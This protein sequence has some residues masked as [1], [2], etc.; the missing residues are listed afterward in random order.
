MHTITFKLAACTTHSD[1]IKSAYVNSTVSQPCI[2][3]TFCNA[4]Y[5]RSVN[6]FA[7]QR[8]IKIINKLIN[9]MGYAVL[10]TDTGS[11]SLIVVYTRY[12]EFV[13]AI[14]DRAAGLGLAKGFNVQYSISELPSMSIRPSRRRQ[15][16]IYLQPAGRVQRPDRCACT[17]QT[18]THTCVHVAS[19]QT[20]NVSHRP[21]S[22]IS[23]SLMSYHAGRQF[24]CLPCH[25]VHATSRQVLVVG[26]HRP[27]HS[28]CVNRTRQV[29]DRSSDPEFEPTT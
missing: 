9:V 3:S 11:N 29:F 18:C 21:P 5:C 16:L 20:S 28:G 17:S 6:I 25:A 27:I 15:Y 4:S 23:V 2:Q 7:L 14:K 10:I 12:S 26:G 1:R 19:S 8:S 24:A 22:E 13:S